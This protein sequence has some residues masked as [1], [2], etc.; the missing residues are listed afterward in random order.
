VT[1]ASLAALPEQRA[2]VSSSINGSGPK[3]STAADAGSDGS[4][5][6]YD[7]LLQDSATCS[8]HMRRALT[9][10]L[11]LATVALVLAG[12][13]MQLVP[14]MPEAR[15]Y[16]QRV[17]PWLYFVAALPPLAMAWRWL[18]WKVYKV[19]AEH[20]ATRDVHTVLCAASCVLHTR[21]PRAAAGGRVHGHHPRGALLPAAA[22]RGA[23]ERLLL[24][25][26]AAVV[27]GAPA[28]A[29]SRA[30]S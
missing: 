19:C 16:Y 20:A 23:R 4:S 29:A 1:K 15:A 13:M 26:S 22:A 3:E 18:W 21:L 30:A 11:L 17:Y 7:L 25:H 10:L 2:Q 14:P 28:S 9:V 6:A 24:A 27:P 5:S 8:R 12:V